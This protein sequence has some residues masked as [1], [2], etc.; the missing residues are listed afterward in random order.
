M[1]GRT[2][3]IGDI[4]GCAIA[5]DT[6]LCAIRPTQ[7]DT[8]VP[9]GDYVDRGPQSADVIEIFTNLVSDCKVIPLVGNHELMMMQALESKSSYDSWLQCGGNTTLAS[10]GNRLSNLPQHH[11]LFLNH[12]VQYYETDTHFFIHA[13]YDPNLELH[14]QPEQLALWTHIIDDI[15]DPH[16]NG[17]IAVVGHTPQMD[18]NVRDL[19]HIKMIDTHCYGNKWLTAMDVDTGHLWQ[20][21][22]AGALREIG[23]NS[24]TA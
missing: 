22:N 9:L 4:H 3:A 21:T 18:G 19:G 13:N 16:K 10:Y 6:L 7:K 5:L 8:V 23:S 24:S 1:P 20:A 17:K 11:R 15:P 12:C 14:E 2:I